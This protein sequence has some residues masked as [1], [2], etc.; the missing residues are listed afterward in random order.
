MVGHIGFHRGPL[1]LDV[2]LSD[3]TFVGGREPDSAAAVE[4]GYTI[5]PEHRGN[6][7]A[8]EAV[9]GLVDWARRSAPITVLASVA[10]ANEP[11][12]RVLDRVGGFTSIGA[13]TDDDGTP[14]RVFRRDLT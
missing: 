13:C 10:E 4:I 3:E 5:F 2:A 8:T 14:E 6:G 9:T 1:P 7:Y 11:S 12:L